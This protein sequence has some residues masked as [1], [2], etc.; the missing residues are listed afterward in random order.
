[1]T[2][3]NSA[4]MT[5]SVASAN[6]AFGETDCKE[7]DRKNRDQREKVGR[8]V[9]R[10]LDRGGLTRAKRKKLNELLKLVR[11]GGMTF[12]S[13]A[14]NLRTGN[15]KAI[16]GIASGAS[17]AKARE[18]SKTDL[19]EGGDGDAKTGGKGIL[20]AKPR[21][22]KHPKGGSGGHAEAK[23]FNQVSQMADKAGGLASGGKVLFNVNW[24]YRQP[25]GGIYESGMPCRTCYRMMCHASKKCGIKI[26]LCDANNEPQEFDP[27]NECD[28]KSKNPKDSP[29]RSLDQRMKEHAYKGRRTVRAP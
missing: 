20:C 15:G 24:R 17:S 6:A 28:K 2:T 5:M 27:N 8:S 14:V 3:G 23:I 13:A 12:S 19:V 16:G 21:K 29:Y 4:A 7:L 26:L 1:M 25:D 18:R 11:D 10:E 22:Y 9:Q